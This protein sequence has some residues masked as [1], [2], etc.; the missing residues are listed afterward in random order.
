MSHHRGS[1]GSRE[2]NEPMTLKA[3]PNE[4][5][6]GFEVKKMTQADIAREAQ[7]DAQRESLLANGGFTFEMPDP[8]AGDGAVKPVTVQFALE[9][10]TY[11]YA[12]QDVPM[13]NRPTV[14]PKAGSAR[15]GLTV[16]KPTAEEK[17][18]SQVVV[19]AV[20]HTF[21]SKTKNDIQ[22]DAGA[23]FT[24]D[25]GIMMQ[26]DTVEVGA[27][28]S[29]FRPDMADAPD[30]L[31]TVA[32]EKYAALMARRPADLLPTEQRT[33]EA[34]R[35]IV[36]AMN[37]SKG[38]PGG[39]VE[40]WAPQGVARF[41]F[42]IQAHEVIV[43]RDEAARADAAVRAEASAR[44]QEAARAEATARVEA[45]RAEVIKR[46]EELRAKE[47]ADNGLD[48]DE[49]GR[50]QELLGKEHEQTK[51]TPEEV[52]DLR[53]LRAKQSNALHPTEAAEMRRIRAEYYRAQGDETM[54]RQARR[55]EA[56]DVY[57]T[58]PRTA[59]TMI[60]EAGGFL[61]RNVGAGESAPDTRAGAV[62][63][64]PVMDGTT[65]TGWRVQ[66]TENTTIVTP[67]QVLPMDLSGAANAPILNA[68]LSYDRFAAQRS[69]D[70]F[71]HGRYVQQIGEAARGDVQAD[72]DKK[73]ADR[74]AAE[75]RRA[76][77]ANSVANAAK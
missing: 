14:E 42:P 52:E 16:E 49:I 6:K 21:E 53:E 13:P 56:K 48:P 55:W 3:H 74:V 73:A 64:E 28:V 26:Q 72:R 45:R 43:A 44:A 51:L 41:E 9:Q 27:P 20:G 71:P 38:L 50:L 33:L 35:P 25:D 70:G 75:A 37:A 65:Q 66:A 30:T 34:L 57:G 17:R 11:T 23:T 12:G 8:D 60:Q 63:I 31:R 39:I 46:Y 58:V 2:S 32:K 24:G 29:K 5:A 19:T 77:Q 54:A 76:R 67:G 62:V 15:T 61:V 7:S 22:V 1:R 59:T 68:V 40:D 47:Q 4:E 18:D 10:G 69:A 36:E